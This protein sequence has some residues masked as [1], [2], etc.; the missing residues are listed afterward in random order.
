MTS[1]ADSPAPAAGPLSHL[2]MGFLAFV[3]HTGIDAA[4]GRA[5]G[6]DDG[7][8]LF[9]RAEGMGLDNGYVRHRHLQDYLSSPLPFLAAAGQR[10]STLTL[11]TALI[12]LRFENAGRL[13]E[14]LA[15]TDLLVGGRLRIGVGSGYAKQDHVNERAFGAVP[16]GVRPRVDAVL[17]DLLD[18]VGGEQVSTADEFFETETAGTPL[19]IRP[20]VASLRSRIA[21]G[22][23]SVAS[24]ERAGRLGIG[25]QVS[26][27]QPGEAGRSFEELQLEVIESY[28]AA[29]R[30]AGHGEGHVSASRQ[31][32]PVADPADLDAFADL[33]ERDRSRQQ[34]MREGGA[35][36]GGMAV[37][38]G[39]VVADAPEAVAAFLAEDRALAAADE[40]VLALPFGHPYPVVRRILTTWAE[41]VVPLLRGA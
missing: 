26:T 39:R 33:I 41:Q 6:L 11:G 13:A 36:I 16:E 29:S 38:F 12:P 10:T 17:H 24:A 28:R 30:A 4:A 25:L 20:Q 27:L 8:D 3:D 15:T 1:P 21:Y 37:A 7:L 31:M 2:G 34:A 23:G 18:F 32:L 19:R 22:A 35:G 9:A 40:L 5:Q 14:D